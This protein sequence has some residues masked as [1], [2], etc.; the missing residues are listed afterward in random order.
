MIFLASFQS[1]ETSNVIDVREL[2]PNSDKAIIA[3][4][5]ASGEKGIPFP[6]G[7]TV[8]IKEKGVFELKLP[9]GKKFIFTDPITGN[10]IDDGDAATV[11]CKCTTGSGCSPVKVRGS[12]Y[13]VM[14]DK[15]SSCDKTVSL[16][17]RNVLIDG[18]IDIDKNI[19]LLTRNADEKGF[20]KDFT[21][22]KNEA[23]S[24]AT[25]GVLLSPVV[26]QSLKE[27]YNLIYEGEVPSFILSNSEN[28]PKEYKY[29]VIDLFGNT[30]A[31]PFPVDKIDTSMYLIDGGSESC[32]CND[33]K[34]KGCKKESLM[35]AV[36]CD[37]GSCVSCSL[38]D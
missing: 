30:A 35:G 26:Q 2:D 36:Y 6:E 4:I 1:C 37:A 32:K 22:T 3:A 33:A 20:R 23:G 17:G 24:C 14:G 21:S 15:C 9:K 12:Y 28:I 29:V 25:K 38:I 31:I 13:C 8:E 16:R 27:F 11:T 18:I 34:P 5:A 19:T 7:S 10:Y